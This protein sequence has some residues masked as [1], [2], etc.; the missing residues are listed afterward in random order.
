[1]KKETI[2]VAYNDNYAGFMLSREAM[3]WMKENGYGGKFCT[4]DG[5]C[6]VPRHNPVLVRCIE[7]L[8]GRANGALKKAGK[9][10]C[11]SDL[12]IAEIDGLK[13]RVVTIDGKETVISEKDLV[14]TKGKG[15]QFVESF[16][17]DKVFFTADTHF[18]DRTLIRLC[19]RPFKDVQEMD[20][21]LIRRY[22]ADKLS[23]V[24]EADYPALMAELEAIG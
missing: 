15:L 1:M 11:M 16:D 12:R 18:G 5:D 6:V 2:K 14:P 17:P 9:I 3:T 4:A 8:G 20:R 24:K 7:E 22:G 13:Y 23:S 19:G 21:E 10:L